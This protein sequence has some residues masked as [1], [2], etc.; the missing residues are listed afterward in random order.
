MLPAE[1]VQLK[2]GD[3]RGVTQ[4]HYEPGQCVFNQGDLGDR[5]YII[6]AGKVDVFRLVD[7]EEQHIAFLSSGDWFGEAALLNQTTRGATVRCVQSLDVLSLPKKEFAVL[8]ANLPDLRK[9]FE[10]MM[11]KR[12]E[13]RDALEKHQLGKS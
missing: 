3:S 5:V 8:A 4:E 1:L 11:E 2:L 10:V 7:G 6:L 13:M 9:S 12:A